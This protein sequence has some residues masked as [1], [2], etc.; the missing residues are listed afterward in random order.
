[1][2]LVLWDSLGHQLHT[3]NMTQEPWLDHDL[4][5]TYTIYD[6]HFRVYIDQSAKDF[7]NRLC[8]T[9]RVH[10]ITSTGHMHQQQQQHRLA[11]HWH[12]LSPQS[13]LKLAIRFDLILD[14]LPIDKCYHPL[15][16]CC[17]STYTMDDVCLSNWQPSC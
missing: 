8:M 11:F 4:N 16:T 12:S 9:N 2:R 6:S 13:L 15:C 5:K 1:M 10:I 17:V 14:L 7:S 3:T